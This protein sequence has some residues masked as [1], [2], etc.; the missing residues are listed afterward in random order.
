MRKCNCSGHCAPQS[1]NL[2]RRDFL[3]WVGA[4]S[5]AA[6]LGGSSAW[7]AFSL[8]PGEW[9]KR[10]GSLLQPATPRRYSSNTHTDARMHLGGIGT[11]N[12]EI[13]V[14]GQLT[15]WQLF[16]NLRDGA[17]PFHFVVKAGKTARLLQ[18][19]GGPDWPRLKHIEMRGEYPLATLRFEDADLPVELEL[20]AFTPFAPLGTELSS[21]PVA[22]FL[23][24]ARNP[25]A[26]PQRLS[27]AAMLANP[28]G[29]DAM[30]TIEGNSYVEFGGNIN[31]CFRE[32]GAAGLLLRAQAAGAAQMDQPVFLFTLPNLKALKAPPADYPE[33]LKLE[34]LDNQPLSPGTLTEPERT[35]L[36][37][38]EP[39]EGLAEPF[40]RAAREAVETGVTL[41]FSGKRMPLLS[42]Y[43]AAT[44]GD[45]ASGPRPD[46]LF[47]DFEQG[48]ERWTVE[49][50]A[51]G[52]EPAHGTL[53]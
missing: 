26:Q 34:I 20:T 39:P 35:L 12:F 9:E 10:K 38:E 8:P 4:G 11:G 33:R 40:L 52:K 43:G 6:L 45:L 14:D 18:T 17:L 3:E 46:I 29:Y 42:L 27:L 21:L 19:A 25:T 30:G 41:V 31:E 1:S 53:A 16:N 7:G 13:G 36:W 23:F 15:N 44:A 37:L 28:V 32:H 49:G 22:F 2:S 50:E 48:Y 47:E 5:A 51:F 24:R